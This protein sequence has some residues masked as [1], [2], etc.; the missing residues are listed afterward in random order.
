MILKLKKGLVQVYTG[1]GKGKT[2]AALGLIMR[3]MGYGLKVYFVQF[4]KPPE[5]FSG[6]LAT[7]GR[8]K[9][10]CQ[11]VRCPVYYSLFK[12]LSAEQRKEWEKAI[13]NIL[14]E[15]R[16]SMKK[17]RYDV[18][19]LDEINNCLSKELVSTVEILDLIRQ[20]PAHVELVLTGR[21]APLAVIRQ[22]DLVTRMEPIKHPFK[23]GIYARKG[24]EY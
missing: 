5:Y 23:K 21:H 9:S 8:F 12:P 20:K 10:Q 1:N 24:I 16:E 19:V 6:E 2:S 11:V 14:G 15:V 18:Y 4:L 22:A 3:A 17:N 7:L 13:F